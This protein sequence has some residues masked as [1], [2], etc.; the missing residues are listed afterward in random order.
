MINHLTESVFSDDFVDQLAIKAFELFESERDRGA[1][2]RIPIRKEVSELAR[3]IDNWIQALGDGLLDRQTLA[4]YIK[5]AQ[6][7]QTI[8]ES[9]LERIEQMQAEREISVKSIR[10]WLLAKRDSLFSADEEAKKRVVQELVERITILPSDTIHDHEIDVVYRLYA[11]QKGKNPS[12]NGDRFFT[13]GGDG[14]RT[15]V[16]C[17]QS[18]MYS[19]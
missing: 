16:R 9:E 14:S 3:K 19:S 1:D 18:G 12:P 8:L 4:G 11:A 17:A 5:Q 13:G 7:R 10:A 6:Q 2:E 15:R